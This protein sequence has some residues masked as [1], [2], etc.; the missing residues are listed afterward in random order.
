MSA[1]EKVV[2][3]KR[4]CYLVDSVSGR[5][6]FSAFTPPQRAQSL[7]RLIGRVRNLISRKSNNKRRPASGS[8]R[9]VTTLMTSIAA[10]DPAV[11]ETALKTGNLR[12]QSGGGSG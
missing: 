10:K 8:P 9:P 1:R 12:F 3:C 2:E 7:L 11:E 6:F 4:T 5:I